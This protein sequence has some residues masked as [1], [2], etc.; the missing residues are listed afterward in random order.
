MVNLFALL[1]PISAFERPLEFQFHIPA[2]AES[3]I[4]AEIADEEEINLEKDSWSC[5]EHVKDIQTPKIS[6]CSVSDH[7]EVDEVDADFNP[8][9]SSIHNIS[10]STT[11]STF[12]CLVYLHD[13][14]CREE[15]DLL[16]ESVANQY[17]PSE[18]LHSTDLRHLE[19]PGPPC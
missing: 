9:L 10:H 8:I 1:V 15:H 19:R 14:V 16:A 2:T 7:S 3:V 6:S 12:T 18:G 4:S 17:G 5:I 13:F 11:G